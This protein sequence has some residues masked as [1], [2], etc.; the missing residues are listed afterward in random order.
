MDQLTPLP[1]PPARTAQT[2]AA[3]VAA[4]D[5][6]LAAQQQFVLEMN[7]TVIPSLNAMLSGL[8]T[9][10]STTSMVIGLGSKTFN[11]QP[12]L[13]FIP[14]HVVL[15][16]NTPDP[17]KSMSGTVTAYNA[18]TGSMT[19]LVDD[20]GGSGTLSVW[21]ISLALSGADLDNY[22]AKVG[23]TLT[24]LLTLATPASGQESL[25]LPHGTDPSSPTDG[26][27]WSKSTGL[28]ARINGVTRQ[29]AMLTGTQTFTDKTLTSPTING[30]TISNATV[31]GA[32]NASTVKDGAGAGQR[33]GYREVPVDA[34][35]AA[36][37]LA[38]GDEGK[39]VLNT[40]GGWSIPANAS[41]AFP[42]GTCI[43]LYNDSAS[44]QSITITTD[45]LRMAGTSNTGTRTLTARGLATL[46]KVKSTEWVIGGSGL[47]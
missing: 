39:L 19:V 31:T 12:N 25:V 46:V 30:G 32:D 43:S 47:A 1:S 26:S 3:F 11:T 21:S 14:G 6:W 20:V 17:S 28:F 4:M 15:I 8:F 24:G 44:S 7:G 40:T 35:S 13:G 22:L 37:A 2:N 5:A 38:L 9:G 27:L 10:S 18:S 16:S 29:V 45:T 41:V 23:G 33:I 42:V 34:A 36:R